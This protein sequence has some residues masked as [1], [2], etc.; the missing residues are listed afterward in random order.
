M[1][2]FPWAII[3]P[4]GCIR[5]LQ[6]WGEISYEQRGGLLQPIS[7]PESFPNP[8]Y[9]Q[10]W[11]QHMWKQF[12]HFPGYQLLTGDVMP[13]YSLF[14]EKHQRLYPY[15]NKIRG[16]GLTPLS[17]KATQALINDQV[18]FFSEEFTPPL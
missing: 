2:R 6:D 1:I 4:P 3:A 9:G 14:D 12:Q 13:Y 16:F 5:F 11:I 7:E 8:D 17:F 10:D 15:Q 18:I